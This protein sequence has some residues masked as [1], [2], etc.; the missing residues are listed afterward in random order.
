MKAHC[1]QAYADALQGIP[2]ALAENLGLH[3]IAIIT[4]VLNRHALGERNAGVNVRKVCA[5]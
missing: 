4:K 2:T 1:F 5:H 3:P